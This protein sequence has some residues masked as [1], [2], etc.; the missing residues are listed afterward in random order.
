[1]QRISQPKEE[2]GATGS[3]GRYDSFLEDDINAGNGH[4]R[5]RRNASRGLEAN[6]NSHNT[7]LSKSQD[8]FS[9][10]QQGENP[11]FYF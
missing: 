10:N 6:N 7:K 11:N 9:S 8:R 3:R 4:I 5:E 1:M 2:N